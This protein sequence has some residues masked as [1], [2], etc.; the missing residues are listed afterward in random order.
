MELTYALLMQHRTPKGGW[1]KAQL[2][3]LGLR[4]PPPQGWI[5]DVVGKEL[6]I[7]QWLQFTGDNLEMSELFG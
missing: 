6:T 1:T 3:A 5:K 7:G 2:Q 4:W